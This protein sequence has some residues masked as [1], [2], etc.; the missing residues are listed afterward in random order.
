VARQVGWTRDH[1]PRGALL[2]RP[3]GS[4]D[5]LAHS[6]SLL[7]RRYLVSYQ[8]VDDYSTMLR[9]KPLRSTKAGMG[10]ER[11]SNCVHS[12]SALLSHC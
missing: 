9:C 1:P 7:F 6:K 11:R 4:A 5:A 10:H 3:R 12:S 2:L 8:P